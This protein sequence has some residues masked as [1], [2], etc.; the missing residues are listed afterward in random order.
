MPRE[1]QHLPPLPEYSGISQAFGTLRRLVQPFR[2]R[3]GKGPID[4]VLLQ[5]NRVN[6]GDSSSMDDLYNNTWG[7]VTKPGRTQW[8]ES[9]HPR[10]VVT[11]LLNPYSSISALGFVERGPLYTSLDGCSH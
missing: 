1:K 10:G 6:I 5:E 4:L 11:M 3:E 7:F 9:E 2:Q 8:T